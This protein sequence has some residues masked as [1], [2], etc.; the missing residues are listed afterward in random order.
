VAAALRRLKDPHTGKD[1]LTGGFVRSLEVRNGNVRLVMKAPDGE[2]HCPQYV[3]L[4]VEAKRAIMAL[5]GVKAV[6][7]TFTGHIQERAVNEALK[8][9][10]KHTVKRKKGCRS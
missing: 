7:A 3:P 9:L 4:A 2:E 10:D 1:I 6:D 5:P 8:L